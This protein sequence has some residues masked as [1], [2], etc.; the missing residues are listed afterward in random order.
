LSTCSVFDLKI[1]QFTPKKHTKKKTGKPMKHGSTLQD[2][3]R[4]EFIQAY[5]GAV[6]N[7]IT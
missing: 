3:P 6:H 4:A 5:I 2:T 1:L 7:A